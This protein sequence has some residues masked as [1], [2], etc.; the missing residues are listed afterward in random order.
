MPCRALEA[1]RLNSTGRS[2][3]SINVSLNALS[4]IGGVQTKEPALRPLVE[5]VRLNALSG[6]GG[7]QTLAA[8][9]FEERE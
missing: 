1:F 2:L 8:I 7:V 5:Q 3:M 9:P 6:I 4:G